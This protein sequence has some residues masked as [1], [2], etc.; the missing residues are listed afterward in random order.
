MSL[1]PTR[2]RLALLAAASRGDVYH[3]AGQWWLRPAEV[4]VTAAVGDQRD[5]GWLDAAP[6][7]RMGKT[8]ACITT[9]GRGVLSDHG[10]CGGCGK[11]FTD[12]IP[13]RVCIHTTRMRWVVCLTADCRRWDVCPACKDIMTGARRAVAVLDGGTS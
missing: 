7:A 5:A 13:S 12:G 1:N 8:L 10:R 3:E 6:A 2:T 4:R 11:P 9:T